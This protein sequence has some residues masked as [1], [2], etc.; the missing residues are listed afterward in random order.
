M[1]TSLLIGLAAVTM[2]SCGGSGSSAVAPTLG[3][4]LLASGLNQPMQYQAVPGQPGLAYVLERGGVIRVLS[5]DVLQAA[6]LMNISTLL[7]SVGEGG[8]FGIAFDPNFATNRY[9]Y[10]HFSTGTDVDTQITR[11]T[12]NPSF[13]TANFSSAFSI[14]R[15][16]QAPYTNHKGGSINFGGDGLL[17]VALGDGGSGND[18]LNR[19]QDKTTLLGKMLRIDP[20]SDAYPVDADNNYSI[21]TGNPFLADSAVRPEI[22]A[23]GLRNPFRWNYDSTLGGF[24]I[25]DVGQDSYEEVNFVA[26]TNGGRNFG[27][28]VREGK[29]SIT[30]PGPTF[31]TV[32]TD[33]FIEYPRSAGRSITGG[34]LYRG[35]DIPNFGG[36]Y[37]MGDYVTNRIWGVVPIFAGGEATSMD[38][39]AA[40]QLDI[41]G[42]LNGV[43]SIDEDHFQ[44]PIITEL[45]AGTVSRLIPLVVN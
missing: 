44:E 9:I 3:K 18:P 24:F 39:S 11:F 28:R 12:V 21:P 27:W 13:L 36:N 19:S 45:N 1:R 25:A 30:N 41:T 35:N 33:P 34:F 20:T 5:A 32:F 23:F 42:G 17:Y 26:Q 38:F 6:P 2:W 4:Q 40:K 14:L 8:L 16:S 37:I 7:S 15:V 29:H 10:L 22:W 31:G 43:V